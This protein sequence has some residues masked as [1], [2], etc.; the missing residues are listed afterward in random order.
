[1]DRQKDK[2]TGGRTGGQMDRWT[3]GR[4]DIHDVLHHEDLLLASMPKSVLNCDFEKFKELLH[5]ENVKY[6]GE[7]WK[8]LG[9]AKQISEPQL[10]LYY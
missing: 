3:N 10:P 7:V 4:T 6:I 9:K 1:M 8:D 2:Q 5:Q